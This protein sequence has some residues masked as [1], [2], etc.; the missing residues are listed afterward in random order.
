MGHFTTQQHHV[1]FPTAS[2]YGCI[3]IGVR[4]LQSLVDPVVFLRLLMRNHLDSG[5]CLLQ[6]WWTEWV[7]WKLRRS[8]A[9][10]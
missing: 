9:M 1:A 4:L 8:G 6:S 10:C 7:A 2:M 5:C 3:Y